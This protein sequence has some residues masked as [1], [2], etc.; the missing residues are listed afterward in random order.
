MGF[1]SRAARWAKTLFFLIAMTISLL[2]FSSPLLLALTDALI[3]SAVLSAV[4]SPAAA[5]SSAA[6]LNYDFRYSL[7][8]IPLLSFLRSF[9]ILSVYSFKGPYLAVAMTCSAASL[10]FVCSKAWHRI[11]NY[12]GGGAIEVALF[13]SSVGLAVGHAVVA[14]RTRCKERRRLMVYKI[15][16]EAVSPL[17]FEFCLTPTTFE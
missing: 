8:D 4:L 7:V 13:V 12:G 3:P 15:D 14:Y 17:E 11:M 6:I 16:I 5:F 2:L 1:N 10:V 9:I